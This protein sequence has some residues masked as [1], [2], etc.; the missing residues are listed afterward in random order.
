ME[1]EESH[2]EDDA[3]QQTIDRVLQGNPIPVV[4]KDKPEM[5]AEQ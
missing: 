1:I 5:A 3:D 2:L 4:L